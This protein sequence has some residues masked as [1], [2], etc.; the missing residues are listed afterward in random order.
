MYNLISC[1]STSVIRNV[2]DVSSNLH[3]LNSFSIV[4]VVQWTFLANWK[5]VEH[6]VLLPG[7]C[8]HAMCLVLC[9]YIQD[10]FIH[11]YPRMTLQHVSFTC[12]AFTFVACYTCTG[13][14][15]F[16]VAN[17]ANSLKSTCMSWFTIQLVC[18]G[19]YNVKSRLTQPTYFM[20]AA[21][22]VGYTCTYILQFTLYQDLYSQT[23]KC[24][25]NSYFTLQHIAN[26]R[27]CKVLQK[28]I[29]K[30]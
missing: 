24:Y 20:L 4:H 25:E 7:L 18:S 29:S 5:L 8:Y 16:Y 11:I 30:Q 6:V 14:N 21:S 26:F 2:H 1:S 23:K 17:H 3:A 15:I 13:T 9:S 28:A 19:S 27:S 10:C 12:W 22:T